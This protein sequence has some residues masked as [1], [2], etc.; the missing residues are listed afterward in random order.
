MRTFHYLPPGVEEQRA[1]VLQFLGSLMGVAALVAMIFATREMAL[2]GL[3]LG[4]I[5]AT[6]WM[7]LRNAFSLENKARRAEHALLQIDDEAFTAVDAREYSQ[8]ILWR[9]V[10]KCQSRGGRLSLQWQGE[11]GA[12]TLEVG[13][14]E[15][16]DGPRLCA[17][18]AELFQRGARHQSA[19]AAVQLHSAGTA[20]TIFNHRDTKSTE[21]KSE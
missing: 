2:R 9:D 7:L 3:L 11:N 10:E 17:R 20:L 4:A 8:R 15:I 1:F 6:I 14:R 16:E 12:Q 21:K 13:A 18:C 19:G 5:G